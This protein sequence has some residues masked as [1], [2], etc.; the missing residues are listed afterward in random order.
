MIQ[1]V[2]VYVVLG[3]TATA[4][5]HWAVS[6]APGLAL[7]AAAPECTVPAAAL[8]VPLHDHP[9]S[10]DSNP[11]SPTALAPAL[12]GSTIAVIPTTAATLAQPAATARPFHLRIHR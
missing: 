9:V 12:A 2:R 3:E 7:S 4:C 1:A 10:P 6:A 8:T 11:G 5:V